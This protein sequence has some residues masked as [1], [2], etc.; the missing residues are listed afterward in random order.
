VEEGVWCRIVVGVS[1]SGWGLVL[2]WADRQAARA[3][4][5]ELRGVGVPRGLAIGCAQILALVPGPSRSGITL[6]AGL[7]AG[8]DRPTAARFTFLLGLPLTAGAGLLK[9]VSLLHHGLA[10]PE[11]T[12]LGLGLLTSFV[13]GVAAVWFV[14]RY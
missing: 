4:V 5:P 11:A 10:A 13:A 9:T 3:R 12:A 8:L 14:I 7:F 6:T 1:T 2:G